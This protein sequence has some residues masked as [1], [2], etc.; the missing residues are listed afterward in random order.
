MCANDHAYRGNE[1]HPGPKRFHSRSTS[2]LWRQSTASRVKSTRKVRCG[3]LASVWLCTDDFRSPPI[4]RH[5]YRASACLKRATSRHRRWVYRIIVHPGEQ[6]VA[7]IE[8][9][10]WIVTTFIIIM[11][12]TPPRALATPEASAC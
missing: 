9:F 6:Q 8:T 10:V 3:S 12:A 7:R 2:W 4:N 1:D 11:A 5:R